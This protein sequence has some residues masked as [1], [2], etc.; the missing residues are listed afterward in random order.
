MKSRAINVIEIVLAA[1][2][3]IAHILWI[4]AHIPFTGLVTALSGFILCSLY[5]YGGFAVLKSPGISIGNSIVLGL[6]FGLA[7]DGLIFTFQKWP[8]A[9]FFVSLGLIALMLLTLINLVAT[10]LLKQPNVLKLNKGI[11]I[12]FILLFAAL[13]YSFIS[14]KY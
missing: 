14:L 12:R 5:F 3:I 9:I 8:Y 7:V 13:L 11:T 10:Y 1:L 6:A 2:F 4:R